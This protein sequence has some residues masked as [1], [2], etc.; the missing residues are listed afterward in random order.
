MKELVNR[1]KEGREINSFLGDLHLSEN[2]LSYS[3]EFIT[4][5]QMSENN[6]IHVTDI[7]KIS[8]IK[9]NRLFHEA[10]IKFL[11]ND[12]E[13]KIHITVKLWKDDILT[14]EQYEENNR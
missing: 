11:N 8:G 4:V 7:E 10:V 13:C 6:I 14:I 2:G 3:F 9:Y 12:L 1:I 5:L